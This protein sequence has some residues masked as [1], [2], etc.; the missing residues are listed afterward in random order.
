MSNKAD[1]ATAP[2]DDTVDLGE[3]ELTQTPGSVLA[4]PPVEA[5]GLDDAQLVAM[6][7]VVKRKDRFIAA[8]KGV[9]ALILNIFEPGDIVVFPGDKASV[10]A[11]GCFRV[12]AFFG[13][14]F[15]IPT[16]TRSHGTDDAG[17]WYRWSYSLLAHWAGRSIQAES[18]ASN[19][20]KFHGFKNGEW[21]PLSEVSEHNV[22][23]H[24]RRQCYAEAVRM[25]F[26]LHKLN[27]EDLEAANVSLSYADDTR[28]A[29]KKG[30]PRTRGGA[31]P[32]KPAA[33]GPLVTIDQVEA[34][35]DDAT[36]TI[37][38][39]VGTFQTKGNRTSFKLKDDTGTVVVST[40]DK[41]PNLSNGDRVSCTVKVRV[42]G[43][44]RY[45][46]L[47]GQP[48]PLPT[49]QKEK[50]DGSRTDQPEPPAEREPGEDDDYSDLAEPGDAADLNGAANG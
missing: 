32:S 9:R 43:N 7:S 28:G 29:F 2:D 5:T 17:D 45:Y 35:A 24:A 6:E 36:A 33:K 13:V 26:G 20:D 44:Q 12:A 47:Q 48:E 19:R 23:T 39:V 22:R 27:V 34:M 16:A 41:V 31:A 1:T 8:W 37:G 14:R 3:E 42:K 30:K 46:N 18:S 25:L 38:G 49:P 10:G 4:P 50:P 40:F 21:K 15:D 11:P